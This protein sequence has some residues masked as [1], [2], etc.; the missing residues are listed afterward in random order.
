MVYV[1]KT[2]NLKVYKKII[3]K[4]SQEYCEIVTT[5]NDLTTYD[6]KAFVFLF[7]LSNIFNIYE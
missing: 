6:L 7:D 2:K 4:N 1:F 5:C 3:P